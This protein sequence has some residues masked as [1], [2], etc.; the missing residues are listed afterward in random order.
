MSC[1]SLISNENLHEK[2]CKQTNTLESLRW[3]EGRTLQPRYLSSVLL[4]GLVSSD[5]IQP[6]PNLTHPNRSPGRDFAVTLI[7][8]RG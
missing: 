8:H 5:I 3:T 6:P 2:S 7:N 1:R 4:E